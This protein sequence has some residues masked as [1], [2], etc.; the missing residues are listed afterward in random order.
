M[1]VKTSTLQE[2]FSKSGIYVY[3]VFYHKTFYISEYALTGC[4]TQ[5]RFDFVTLLWA[6]GGTKDEQIENAEVIVV[7]DDENWEIG[8]TMKKRDERAHV[9]TVDQALTVVSVL[10][11]TAS[12]KTV[13]L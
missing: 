13:S 10:V 5:E 12:A 3:N 2:L 9:I 7:G 1:R 6:L 4:L 8:M 11:R